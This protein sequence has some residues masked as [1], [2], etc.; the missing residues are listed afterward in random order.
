M[1]RPGARSLFSALMRFSCYSVNEC[2]DSI[3]FPL[4]IIRYYY[5]Q[6]EYGNRSIQNYYYAKY[7]TFV[8]INR[9]E[10]LNLNAHQFL[11]Q[12]KMIARFSLC[13]SIDLNRI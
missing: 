8:K 5:F 12:E 2:I 6:T 10:M 13:N 11:S 9:L 7:K 3:R 4:I 1:A